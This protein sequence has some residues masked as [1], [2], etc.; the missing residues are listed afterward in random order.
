MSQVQDSL[1]FSSILSTPASAAIWTDQTRTS[2]YLRFEA[3]LAK[4]QA[5]L[6]I[7]PQK[8]ADEIVKYCDVSIIDWDLLK[9]KTKIIGY[10]VLGVIQQLV[11]KANDALPGEA[12][13]ECA[14]WGATT[15]VRLL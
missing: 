9:V 10:P 12:L 11:K 4:A 7:I 14:H 8:A 5:R 1:I 6:N 15:Q 13:G 3:A 2:Y